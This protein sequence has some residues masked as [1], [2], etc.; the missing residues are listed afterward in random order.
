MLTKKMMRNAIVAAACSFTLVDSIPATDAVRGGSA[1]VI[2]RSIRSNNAD[3][4]ISA[5]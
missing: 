4:I 5:L 2:R 3:S 1:G